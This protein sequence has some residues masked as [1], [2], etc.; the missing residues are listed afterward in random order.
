MEQMQLVIGNK[1]YS[2]WSMRAWLAL[3]HTQAVFQE[4]VVPL[5]VPGYKQKL[6]A[7]APTGKVPVL[8]AD[9]LA[10]WDSL[11]ICEYLAERFPEARL[12]P[13]DTA[14]RAEARSVSAEM[15]SGFPAIR[16]EYPFNCRATDRHVQGTGE[17]E[18]EI[19]RV[20]A[21]WSRCRE[22][23]GKGGPWLFGH[24]TTA[25]CMYIP[26]A[27]RFVTYGTQL[28]G[29]AADYVNKMQQ[30]PAVREWVAAAR[31]EKE[32]IEADEVGRAR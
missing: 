20:Q 12:W 10:I 24:F 7:H 15:H 19:G 27:L 11:A 3:K 6:L 25:D 28:S 21:L 30:F 13:Q 5:D 22:R 18:R 1:A 23:F 16:R 29:T 31:L 26:V 14:A 2:S 17:L 4:I 8:K 32:I 9:G